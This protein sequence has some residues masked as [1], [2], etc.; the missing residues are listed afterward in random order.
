MTSPRPLLLFP[1]QCK[2]ALHGPHLSIPQLRGFLQAH[3]HDVDGADLNI[4]F[5]RHITSPAHMLGHLARLTERREALHSRDRLSEAELAELV[6]LCAIDAL[7][8]RLGDYGD[9]PLLSDGDF[10][11]CLH[12]IDPLLSQLP[13]DFDD[14]L[15]A[16]ADEPNNIVGDY[17]DQLDLAA[18]C[19]DAAVVGISVAFHLQL[20][21]ALA[22]ARR[23]RELGGDDVQIVLGG[24]QISLMT[25]A[26]Q[27]AMV[28]RGYIDAIV[29]HEGEQ[30]LLEICRQLATGA[31]VDFSTVP[32]TYYIADE[33]V[34]APV[35]HRPPPMSELATPSFDDDTLSQYLAPQILP[36]YVS[37]GCYWGRCKFCDYTKLYTPGQAKSQ[38]WA[39]FRPPEML[40]TDMQTLKRRHGVSRFY[41]VSEAITPSYYK[42][43]SR[44]LLARHVSVE[45][46]S[47]CRIEKG[48]DYKFFQLLKRAGVKTLTF[49]VEATEDRVLKL[50]DKGNTV[51]DIR[52]TIRAASAAG[53]DVVFNLIP[54]Y[55]TITWD[56]VKRTIAFLRENIDFI[57]LLN[58]QFFD[59]S[60][61]SPIADQ[62]EAHGLT[63]ERDSNIQTLHG[64]HSLAFARNRG[65]NADQLPLVRKLFNQ[66]KSD[67]AVYRRTRELS[68]LVES[69]WFDWDRARFLL[70]D[71]LVSFEL[72]FDPAQPTTV[73][74]ET[75]YL[76]RDKPSL[77]LVS[78]DTNRHLSCAAAVKVVV[79]TAAACGVFSV[80]DVL[81]AA[82]RTWRLSDPEKLRA[83]IIGCLESLLS[84][85]FVSQ[86][87][88]PWLGPPS[89]RAAAVIA[90]AQ[91]AADSSPAPAPPHAVAALRRLPIAP[92]AAAE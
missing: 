79:E 27:Q 70:V 32:N 15:A 64:V 89:S 39:V 58:H 43:L 29:V 17:Y 81:A 73:A 2:T 78:P 31:R 80:D 48:Y 59:L 19:G 26:Q 8:E 10:Q 6:D 49:G 3:G 87:F 55:P 90:Q 16:V 82:A 20:F 28:E 9:D 88:H 63:V 76:R 35:W 34:Q 23:I 71:D 5:F 22:L 7:R 38:A 12:F 85:G 92:T 56:E 37:K 25:A 54:D 74:G 77:M 13:L 83:P 75:Q 41:L 40:V 50:I 1:P 66:L 62:Q 68:Q 21:P 60:A 65:L 24:S 36:V 4:G 69:E 18:L 86:V 33:R 67:I 46:F 42:K 51:A 57:G 53:V 14:I 72:A 45:M 61:N 52:N 91:R 44:Q 84:E 30:P 11:R 47:Y